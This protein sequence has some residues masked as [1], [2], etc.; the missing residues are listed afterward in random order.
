MPQN[1]EAELYK[2]EHSIFII[3]WEATITSVA[4]KKTNLITII[5]AYFLHLCAC[6]TC[7]SVH[8]SSLHPLLA[9]HHLCYADVYCVFFIF[10]FFYFF[11][12]L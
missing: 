4:R 8:A 7:S 11:L 10:I 6:L 12:Y 2:S 9:Y 3:L 1:L 5:A